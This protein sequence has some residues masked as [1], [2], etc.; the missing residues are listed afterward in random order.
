MM[1]ESIIWVSFCYLGWLR[2]VLF[3]FS[4]LMCV[5]WSLTHKGIA[6]LTSRCASFITEQP[7][8]E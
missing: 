7:N 3:D 2:Q 8:Y 6:F 5:N 4:A 1:N